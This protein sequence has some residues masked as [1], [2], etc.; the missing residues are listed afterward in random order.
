MTV[1]NIVVHFFRSS[2]YIVK[3][4]VSIR[5]GKRI[6]NTAL[7]K[8]VPAALNWINRVYPGTSYRIIN[9]K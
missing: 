3:V 7:L 8:D 5:S 6:L 4:S 2:P 9:H 1:D